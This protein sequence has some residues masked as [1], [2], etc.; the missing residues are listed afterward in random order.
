MS[1]QFS[2]V[3]L[4]NL[5]NQ[6]NSMRFRGDDSLLDLSL[7]QKLCEDKIMY[8]SQGGAQA[9]RCGHCLGSWT[10]YQSFLNHRCSQVPQGGNYG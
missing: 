10:E 4:Y 1:M 7:I 6:V 9:H 2:N 3:D 5:L 8:L